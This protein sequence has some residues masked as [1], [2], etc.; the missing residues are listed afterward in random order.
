MSSSLGS[1]HAAH[2]ETPG[3]FLLRGA[4]GCDHLL[5]LEHLPVF[6]TG[7]IK[8]RLRAIAAVLGATTGLD[9]QQGGKLHRI[10]VK[11]LAVY[12]LRA[13]QQVGKRQF[14]QRLHIGHAPALLCGCL[15][16]GTDEFYGMGFYG[17]GI[18]YNLGIHGGLTEYDWAKT[19][20]HP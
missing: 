17:P 9:R 18:S 10:R 12:P 20:H 3:A 19:A 14:E 6:H 8:R 4:R 16:D 1:R 7:G 11:M 13:I 5:H 15:F 2:A